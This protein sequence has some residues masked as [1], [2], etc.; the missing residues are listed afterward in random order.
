MQ[1]D[2]SI[3]DDSSSS[4]IASSI[5]SSNG[6]VYVDNCV[7]PLPLEGSPSIRPTKVVRSRTPHEWKKTDSFSEDGLVMPTDQAFIDTVLDTNLPQCW[8]EHVHIESTRIAIPH[9]EDGSAQIGSDS[10]TEKR[11][12]HRHILHYKGEP[13]WAFETESVYCH[14]GAFGRSSNCVLTN[15]Q[16]RVNL[17]H[18]GRRSSGAGWNSRERRTYSLTKL[19]AES[20]RLRQEQMEAGM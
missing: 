14:K 1:F 13:I 20:G 2:S 7:V 18:K 8:S 4:S 9:N 3:N 12:L 17:L 6:S 19:V 5:A 11:Y 10:A 16:L 15:D